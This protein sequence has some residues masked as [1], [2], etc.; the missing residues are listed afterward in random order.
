MFVVGIGLLLSQIPTFL[1]LIPSRYLARLPEPIANI[2]Y[3]DPTPILPTAAVDVD[4]TGLLDQAPTPTSAATPEMVIHSR[5][6]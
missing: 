6:P 2:A 4:T 5:R 1:R 3:T